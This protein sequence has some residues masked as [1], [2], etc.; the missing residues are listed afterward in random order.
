MGRGDCVLQKDKQSPDGGNRSGRMRLGGVERCPPERGEEGVKGGDADP[1]WAEGLGAPDTR[2][3]GEGWICGEGA[4]LLKGNTKGGW[5]AS[6]GL[7]GALRCPRP[8]Q[9]RWGGGGQGGG[10]GGTGRDPGNGEMGVSGRRRL[11]TGVPMGGALR[12]C[13]R[14]ETEVDE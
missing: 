3:A 9:Q 5:G 10:G 14:G 7:G 4:P 1:A 6:L 12:G 11:E 8:L 13:C 2:R